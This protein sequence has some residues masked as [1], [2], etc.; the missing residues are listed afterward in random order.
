[1]GLGNDVEQ[2]EEHHANLVLLPPLRR[3]GENRQKVVHRRLLVLLVG[4]R[5]KVAGRLTQRRLGLPL[6]LFCMLDIQ[7]PVGTN[8]VKRTRAVLPDPVARGPGPVLHRDVAG[9]HVVV[10]LLV[11]HLHIRVSRWQPPLCFGKT[12]LRF[13]VLPPLEH[14][15]PSRPGPP[16]P[17]LLAVADARGRGGTAGASQPSVAGDVGGVLAVLQTYKLGT[18]TEP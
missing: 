7:P 18:P 8:K 9:G 13:L 17:V 16:W 10:L 12:N 2:R 11:K 6:V 5:D 4:S 1:M 14:N 3:V 15:R